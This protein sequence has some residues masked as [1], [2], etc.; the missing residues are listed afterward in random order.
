M[1]ILWFIDTNSTN[2]ASYAPLLISR[3]SLHCGLSQ[4]QSKQTS[5]DNKHP[6]APDPS[7]AL[8]DPRGS[9]WLTAHSHYT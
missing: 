1:S 7:F 8:L 6:S 5:P 2:K 4:Q 9:R 3:E